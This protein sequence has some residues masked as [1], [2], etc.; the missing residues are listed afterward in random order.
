MNMN[1][2]EVLQRPTPIPSELN[3]KSAL[4]NQLSALRM[5]GEQMYM[6]QV[7]NKIA[8]QGFTRLAVAN[9]RDSW[10]G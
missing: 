9:A 7:A 3:F 2:V 10:L 5:R 6:R 1:R 4:D 8:I